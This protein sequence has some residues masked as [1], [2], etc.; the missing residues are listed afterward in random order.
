MLKNYLKIAFRSLLR[1]RSISFINIVGLAVG[2]ACCLLIMLFVQDE[3]S[4]DRQNADASRIYRIA[5]DFVNDDG[6]RLPDATTPTALAPAMQ[7]ELPE[8]ERVTRVF[9]AWGHKALME[10]G[11]KKFLEDR[12][13]RIDS[14]FF[15]IFT[16]RFVQGS[17]ATAF[18]AGNNSVVITE[19]AAKKYFGSED[20]M[21]K[22]LLSDKNSMLVTGIIRDV[23]EAAHFH[24]DFLIPLRRAVNNPDQNWGQYNFYT[25]VKLKP[26]ARIASVMPKVQALYQRNDKEGKNIF[27]ATALTDIHLHSDLKWEIEPNGNILYVVA[28]SIIGLFVVAIACVN[29]INLS[30][31]KS[32]LRTKEIGIRKVAGAVRGGL[33]RQFL[34]ESIVTVLFAFILALLLAQAALPAMNQLVQKSLS[35][36]QLL[37][38]LPLAGI[39][40]SIALIGLLAGLYPA[41]YLSSIKPVWVLKAKRLPENNGFSLRKVLVVFQFTITISLI[42]GTAIVLQQLAFIRNA[43]LGLDKD[44]VMVISDAGGLSRSQREA[45]QNEF[46]K[47]RGIE[48]VSTADGIVGGLNWTRTMKFKGSRNG[49]LVN[50][51]DV[52]YDYLSVLGIQ[53]KE[54]RSF[55]MDYPADSIAQNHDPSKERPIGSVV[56]NEKAI[57][58]LGVTEPAVGKYVS[59]GDDGDTVYYVR[60]VGVAKDFHF[61][62]FKSEIKPFGFFVDNG[63]QDNFTLKVDAAGV[64]KTIAGVE[65]TWT[66]Y[67]NGRPFR[68]SFLDDT[69]NKLYQSDQ[70][71]NKVVLY[72]T[73]LAITIG[74]M[75]LFGL[76]AF[77]IERRAKEIG[78]RKVVGA[79]VSGIVLL[80][81]KD[82]VQ[83]VLLSIVIA[84]PIAWF[85]MDHWLAN[86]A[87]RIRIEW[88]VFVLAG[89]VA[90]VIALVTVSLQTIKAALT[91]PIESLRSE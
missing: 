20:P 69:F 17:A 58:D 1:H 67:A 2:M 64:D 37:H 76:T 3:L 5:K 18:S 33:I 87:Y 62:S 91:N 16:V 11:D 29:Y 80:L 19:S 55:S 54:G 85:A 38:P 82:F 49:Q 13:I 28:F 51:L 75:G 42:I 6:T 10:Y 35:L 46:R 43:R 61:A 52:G 84:T 88:W 59:Y 44:Q 23:P 65:K 39:L 27:F 48:K 22:T 34:I 24:Y 21:H 40:A 66:T 53:M 56:L 31:A 89:A 47:I 71:F 9:P 72:L 90:V 73:V 68:Y 60:I 77:M 78:I 15:D 74:C 25:Y 79:S 63:Y 57:K 30:T 50:F 41:L 26:G 70:R 86:F 83:L 8:V 7:H 36:T 12:Y 14:S 32:A 81:S 45:L 4:Y